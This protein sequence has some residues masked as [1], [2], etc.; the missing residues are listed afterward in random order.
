MN[1]LSRLLDKIPEK[2]GAVM[3]WCCLQ[4]WRALQCEEVKE[5]R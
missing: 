3:G 4:V 1:R 2:L 5:W